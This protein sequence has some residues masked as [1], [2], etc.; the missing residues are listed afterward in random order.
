M[1]LNIG[2]DSYKNPELFDNYKFFG[3]SH[4]NKNEWKRVNVGDEICGLKVKS[5]S[6]HFRVNDRDNYTFPGRYF[7]PHN[8][9]IEL[10]G[11][12]EAE[13]FLQVN[14]RTVQYADTSELV[15]FYPT[16]INL[17]ITPAD[18][19]IN[20]EGFKTAFDLHSVFDTRDFATAGE[21]SYVVLGYLG[22]L[23][24]DTDGISTGDIAYVRVTLGNI[25]CSGGCF[26]ASL[27]KVERISDILKHIEDKNSI[28]GTMGI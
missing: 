7:D 6:A 12:V 23:G 20:S 14:N 9:E 21:F 2:Y 11:T 16:S 24:I 8:A 3:E 17:P 25:K 5:A 19:L 15:W 10:E 18:Y 26:E 4:E 27:E 1:P 22:D 13:G 28:G